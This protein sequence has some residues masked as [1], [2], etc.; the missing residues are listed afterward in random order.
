VRAESR[1]LA[2]R[3]SGGRQLLRVGLAVLLTASGISRA[4]MKPG[5]VRKAYG[6]VRAS[7]IESVLT[8]VYPGARV[9]WDP[10]LTVK[11]RGQQPQLVEVPV[12]VRGS[13][14]TGGFEGIATIELERK[15]EQYIFEAE[16]FRRSDKPSF[17]TELIVFR[18]DAAGHLQ[19]YKRI[20]LDPG[21]PLTEVKDMSLQ[22]RSNEEWPTAQILYQ[23]HRVVQG[24]FTTIE[25]RAMWDVNT[26]KFISR[27]PLGISKTSKSGSA[28]EFFLELKRTNP[29]TLLIANR[30]GGESHP[31]SCSDPCVVDADTLLSDFKLNVEPG[32]AVAENPSVKSGAPTHVPNARDGSPAIIHLKNGQ[33]IHADSASLAG[34]TIEYTKGESVYKIPKDS[35]QEIVHEDTA[36]RQD[37][38]AEAAAQPSCDPT[39]NNPCHIAFFIQVLMGLG[40]T[41]RFTLFDNAGHNITAQAQWTIEDTASEVDF[42]LVGG[43]PQVVGKKYG[44]VQLYATVGDRTAMARI[45]IVTPDEI[46]SNSAGRIGSPIFKDRARPLQLVPAAPQIGR[47]P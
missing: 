25:W 43:L 16:H 15:K 44:M 20:M 45:Y 38:N 1:T 17:A 13:A 9:Q 5:D 18:A 11:L 29:S 23:A 47:I 46:S 4:Q 12:Y 40:E 8:T 26:E 30:L 37:G 32:P 31:Y 28:R 36:G 19:N 7:L 14:A 27:L 33:T 34:E 21:E 39:S 2:T 6:E 35:V 42:S 41:Q 10:Q 24:S 3:L 22:E